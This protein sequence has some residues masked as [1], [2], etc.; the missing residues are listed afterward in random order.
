MYI[1]VKNFME[2]FDMKSNKSILKLMVGFTLVSTISSG[3]TSGMEFN[4]DTPIQRTFGIPTQRGRG[5]KT[6]WNT[7]PVQSG[8]I[9]Q[10]WK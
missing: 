2:D 9:Q 6:P 10:P 5:S 1:S 8:Y 4:F 3:V 7:R